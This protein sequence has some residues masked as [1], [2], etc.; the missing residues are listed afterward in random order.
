MAKTRDRLKLWRDSSLPGGMD[1]LHASC[2]DYRY[3]AHSHDEFVIAAFVR[4]AQRHRIARYQGIAEPGTLMIIPPGEVHTGEAVECDLGWDYCAFYPTAQFMNALAAESL[5]GAGTLDFGRDLL[6][7]NTGLAYGLLQ[8]S[9]VAAQSQEPLE[10]HCA[11]YDALGAIIARYGQ[12]TGRSLKAASRPADIKKAQAFLA[13]EFH[14]HLSIDEVA[15]AVGISQYH[16]MRSFRAATGLSVHQFLTQIRLNHAKTLL[17]KGVSAA[18]TAT[19]VGFYD[20]SHLI[21]QFRRYFGVTPKQY[22]TTS[23]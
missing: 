11:I 8:A 1:V 10:R 14:G 7:Q 19:S 4:G 21:N 13:D 6:R 22:A 15:S 3:P 18:Q 12:R 2:F 5:P 16:L 20:Q 9:L 17:A 23:R